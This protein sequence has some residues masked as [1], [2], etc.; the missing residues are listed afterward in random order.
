MTSFSAFT[1]LVHSA[2]ASTILLALSAL[3]VSICRQPADR[4]RLIQWSL[5]ATL[6]SLVLLS[7]PSFSAFSLGVLSS[8]DTLLPSLSAPVAAE[9]SEPEA[10][11]SAASL[12]NSPRTMPEEIADSEGQPLSSPGYEETRPAD[13]HKQAKVGDISLTRLAIRAVCIAYAFGM[14]AFLIRWAR[15]RMGLIRMLRNAHEVPAA[16]HAELSRI[17]GAD[18]KRIRLFASADIIVPVTWGAR[19]PVIVI[20][21]S[22]LREHDKVRLRYYLAHEWAH[23]ARRDFG[24]WQ[25][26][27]L[28]QIFL[29]YQPIFWW[30]RHRLAICMD[31]LADADASDQGDST[32]D[33]ADFLVQLARLR[34]TPNPQLTL[35]IGDKRSCLQQRVVFLLNT[36]SRPRPTCPPARNL[37]IGATALLLAAFVSVVRLDAQPTANASSAE[38]EGDVSRAAIVIPEQQDPNQAESDVAAKSITYTG[39]VTDAITAEPIQGVKV[40]VIRKLSRDPETGGWRTLETTEHE[41]G[42]DGRYSFVL[43][44]D[45]VAE[46]S[47]YLEVEAHHPNYAAKGRSGYSHAMIRKNLAMGEQPFYSQ[48]RLWPGEAITATV[49][50]PAGEPLAGVEISMYSKSDRSKKLFRGSF[51]KTET[52]ANGVFRIVPATP[53]DG[54]LWITPAQ[55]SPQAHRIGDRRGNWGTLTVQKGA[56]LAG[57]VLDVQGAPVPGVR[58]EARRRGDGEKA[59]E[60]LNSNA[61]ANQIG[62]R[63]VS[64]PAGEFTLASL[65]DGDYTLRIRSDSDS[66][67]PPPLSQVFLRQKVSIVD[68]TAPESLEIRAVPHVVIKGTYLNSAGKPRTGHELSL[69]GRMD[70]DFYFDRSSTPGKDGKFEVKVPHGLQQAELDLSTNE[71]SSLRWRLSPDESLKRGRRI[72]LGTVEDDIA[73]LEVVRYTAPILLVKPVDDQGAPIEDCT[74][75]LK[76]VRD[77][78]GKEELTVYT[79]GS[80]VSFESQK[81]GRWR[82]EQLLPDEP[83]T[84]TVEKTG[85][86]TTTQDLSL[87]EGGR[88]EL[89]FVMKKDPPAE[90]DEAAEDKAENTP[91]VKVIP[92]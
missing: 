31:Q 60:F 33:Y 67:D 47:L 89:V 7:I 49:V 30:L 79:T 22:V 85:Y 52:D 10:N 6:F 9:V 59:D 36:A 12:T 73:G 50:N 2:L 63:S 16:V 48:I 90:A 58:I 88:R 66:Y 14:M 72:K 21:S 70:G 19:Q 11:S 61:V 35:G 44:P 8:R 15:A 74:P 92:K 41:T 39:V 55:Y 18:V 82:S 64:G 28:L 27:T 83:I 87:P 86:S 75:V 65:P 13:S 17:A 24:T 81:D 37:F 3:A 34:L 20:P 69:F 46:D 32:A 26:A 80:H 23:V 62:R 1:W 51:D 38:A 68:G 29:Y 71:H 54:V 56:T 25:F 57:R 45:Q 53:G 91:E 84:V 4:L 77:T 76:Y 42:A 5:V 40:S 43:P 78:Q